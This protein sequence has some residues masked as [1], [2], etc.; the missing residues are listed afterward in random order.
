MDAICLHH[1]KNAKE[2]IDQGACDVCGNDYCTCRESGTFMDVL[3]VV[4]VV[5]GC[6]GEKVVV[7]ASRTKH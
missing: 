7:S 6:G 1:V 3:R 4:V 2:S 5:E